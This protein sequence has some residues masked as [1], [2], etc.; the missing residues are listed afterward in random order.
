MAQGKKNRPPLNPGVSELIGQD[1]ERRI[2]E[3]ERSPMEKAEE[4]AK[5]IQQNKAMSPCQV[6]ENNINN[7]LA[8]F[9]HLIPYTEL[10]GF[11]ELKLIELKEGY[12]FTTEQNMR[13]GMEANEN[14]HTH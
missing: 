11:L 8:Q 1:T 5:E 10:V 12:R 9:G 14:G 3:A 4:Q 2:Q 13:R 7:Y 6:F